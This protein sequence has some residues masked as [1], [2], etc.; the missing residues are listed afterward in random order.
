[1]TIQVLIADDHAV[2]RDG[3]QALLNAQPDMR[4]VGA[5]GD[6]RSAI[7]EA[8]RLRPNVVVMDIIMPDLNG[9]DACRQIRLT[10]PS[11]QVIILSMYAA[12]EHIQRALRAGAL[13]YVLKE[14]AGRELIEAVRSV[15]ERR[16]YLSES[17]VESIING[18]GQPGDLEASQLPLEL[19]SPRERE[20]LQLVAEGKTS[21]EI[22]EIL[23]LSPKTVDTYRRRLMKKLG[24]HNIPTLV[25]F[26][27]QQGLIGLE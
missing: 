8:A 21:A 18:P 24:I 5:V 6:G 12:G 22:G 15:A 14:S 19:L 11:T 3:L 26:A 2:V 4:V 7:S 13:G 1:M 17:V 9:I 10:Q 23:V 20:V 27:I 25:K 16:R